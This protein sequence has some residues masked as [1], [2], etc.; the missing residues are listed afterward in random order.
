MSGSPCRRPP[1]R[2]TQKLFTG[3]ITDVG[4]VSSMEL[5]GD[6]RIAIETGF[7]LAAIPL[8]ASIACSGPCLTVVEKGAG[9][10]SV[11]ASAETLARTTL[12]EWSVGTR[13][14]L[15]QSLAL[16]ATLD[17]HLVTGH[18]DGTATLVSLK[19]QG[20]SHRLSFLVP[21]EL[22]RFIARKGSVALDG[23]SLTVNEVEDLPEGGTQFGINIIPHTWEVT[24]FGDLT[25]GQRVNLEID[26]IARYVQRLTEKV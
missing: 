15:E 22:G 24:S 12:G 6:T 26:L 19:S 20:D 18:V 5:R 25:V 7:D 4:R 10:F 14:N 8:G 17:G 3:I 16:G 13:V 23:I 21:T 2:G 11:D 1:D 9:S